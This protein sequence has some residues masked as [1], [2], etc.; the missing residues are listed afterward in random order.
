MKSLPLFL[1]TLLP[2]SSATFEQVKPILEHSCVECHNADKDKGDLRLD[3][4]AMFL[5]G[6][7]SGSP[8][9]F[10]KPAESELIRRVLL[11]HDDDEFMPPSS[12][13]KQRQPL[14]SE[15]I[16]LLKTWIVAKAPW[17]KDATLQHRERVTREDPNQAD[18]ELV[19]IGVYPGSVTLETKRDYHRL[20]VIATDKNSVTRDVTASALYTL[21]DPKFAR[22]EGSTL[23]P[24]VDGSTSLHVKF[25]G[26]EVTVP[27][28]VKN[29][30]ADRRISF[31]QDIVPIFTASGCNTGSCHGSA[32]GQDGFMLS[33]FG[34]DPKGD[35]HRI[36]REQ[37][38]RRL[39]LAIPEDSLL[40]TKS[41]GSV[42][43]TGGKLFEKDHPFYATMLEWIKDGANYDPDDISLPVKIEVEP[44]Q[45]VLEGEE[46]NVPLT[47]KATY[48]DGTDRDVTTLSNFTSS[49]DNSVGIDPSTGIAVS[50]KRG[51]GFLM[52]RFHTF[53][54]GSQAIVI[55]DNLEYTR[56]QIATNNYIDEHVHEKLH[57]LRI[58][59][60][61]LCSDEI[62]ARRVYLDIVGLLPTEEELT[63]FLN[64]QNP[65]KRSVLI[66]QLLDRKDFTELWV[67][68]WAELL[69]IRT[70]G[71]NA[72]DVTYKA[73]L[74]W[75]NW[76]RDQIAENR[77]F[78]EIVNEMLSARGGTHDIPATNYFK[79]ESDV[80]KLTENVAQVFMGTRIQ[81]AQCHN[82]PFDRW[83]MDDYYGFVS[84]FTQVKR[85]RG[86]DPMEQIIYDGGGSIKHPV[87][88][89]NAEPKFLGGEEVEVKNQTRRQAVAKWLTTPGNPWFARNTANIVWSHFFG[90]GI[91][92]PVDDV[93]ISNPAT[94]PALLD[95]LGQK[96]TEYNFDMK[97]LV[98]DICNSR[99]YQL[100]TRTNAT[101]ESDD[102]NFSHARIRRL[103]AEVLLDT[104]AQVTSTPNKFRGLPLGSRAV[105]IADGN[106]ST[107]FLT[108][109][110]R[111]TRKTVCSCEVKMEPNLSQALHLLN[112]DAVNNRIQRGQVIQNLQK[113]GKKP[114]EVIKSLYLRTLSRPPTDVELSSLNNTLSQAKDPNQVNQI[115]EDIFW[116]L[117]NS[118]EYLFNH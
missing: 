10:D 96:F 8:V 107:Y 104:L 105:N 68:K 114:E 20:I 78:N 50:K 6:G 94:N 89:Q 92:D 7:D 19:S 97:K 4:H 22:L 88:G 77:P 63:T 85:K 47:V 90:I 17:P 13:K 43:H 118:K 101:N 5:E 52:A 45:F 9:D 93:R 28:T 112:G 59:P 102:T 14:T 16:E 54:E 72:N 39:N 48:S 41:I 32:R 81:C 37:S 110:G 74:L 56:P 73:A 95:A 84:F 109:F 29:A 18:P 30:A 100:S 58:I 51:E 75:Y 83:T 98:R 49:N 116:A 12:K 15:E 64:N 91:V 55:P 99:T 80:K 33:L 35:Y 3:N 70:T 113:E 23:F 60:S 108:T 38:G 71:N 42:P 86:E 21:A 82:H 76:L 11:P 87:T 26:K 67:M 40:L 106:T 69:Q 61:E 24:L 79:A 65:N 25:R 66:D 62:F 46:K 1:L 31:Q 115:L 57:K 111:A 34:Y 36:T 44:K 53:T 27:L 117:L 2:A 103:R